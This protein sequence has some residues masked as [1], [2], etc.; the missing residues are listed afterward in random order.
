MKTNRLHPAATRIAAIL[1]TASSAA[2]SQDSAPTDDLAQI[3]S[4]KQFATAQKYVASTENGANKHLALGLAWLQK[5][6]YKQA[7][8]EFNLGLKFD[9][10]NAMLN[11]LNGYDYEAEAHD[12]DVTKLDL[13]IVGYQLALQFDP[14]LR[15]AALQLGYIELDRHNWPAAQNNFARAVEIDPN[16]RSAIYALAYASYY[17]GDLATAQAMMRRLPEQP[18]ESP[19]IL[20][21]RAIIAAATGDQDAAQRYLEAYDRAEP[22]ANVRQQLSGRVTRWG[23]TFSWLSSKMTATSANGIEIA[24][25]ALPPPPPQSPPPGA[26]SDQPVLSPAPSPQQLTPLKPEGSLAPEVPLGGSGGEGAKSEDKM[27]ILDCVIIRREE[28]DSNSTGINLLDGLSLQF[29]GTLMNTAI[30][31]S[32]DLITSSNTTETTTLGRQFTLSVPA[33]T[34]SLNIANSQ[35]STSRIIGRPSIVAQDGEQSEF[36]MGSEVT[37]ITSGGVATYGTSFSK[38]VGLS[39]RV[40]PDFLSEGRIK[41]TVDAEFLAFE[42]VAA[43][44]FS[45]AL[46]TAKNRA[47][48]VATMDFGRTLV[49]GGGSETL[50]T[51]LDSGVPVL[52][53]VPGLQY[54]FSNDTKSKTERSLLILMTPRRPLSLDQQ[55][56]LDTMFK[57]VPGADKLDPE[58]LRQLKERYESWF[59]PT[60]NMVQALSRMTMTPLYQEFRGGDLD[61]LDLDTVGHTHLLHEQDR[62][63][64]MLQDALGTLYF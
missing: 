37:Y 58:E 15:A 39:L 50:E 41:L 30:S 12:G 2:C 34:Y 25:Q 20:R 59:H 21:A 36:F 53:D 52:R 43:G 18:N 1:L 14:T 64:R 8:E 32:K 19:E 11:F 55:N 51:N 56:S 10:Q 4:P 3:L 35:D 42:P 27:V 54:L 9:P 57:Q 60:S 13:A 23:Q 16:D 63:E 22:D 24:Q 28:V 17:G 6:D 45:Q 46:Q 47:R 26:P 61:L 7:S 48:V 31:K 33:V 62:R 29:A 49:I 5:R 38:E 40:R 44:T